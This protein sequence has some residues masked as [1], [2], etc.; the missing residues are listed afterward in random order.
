MVDE[1]LKKA[2]LE[3]KKILEDVDNRMHRIEK[4]FIWNTIFGFLKFLVIWAPIIAGVIYFTPILK[5]Y[6]KIFDP[7]IKNFQ[8][9]TANLI[10]QGGDQPAQLDYAMEAFCDPVARDAMVEEFCK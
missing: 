9:T 2:I 4:K 6:V 1:E 3:N 5:D 10:H 8:S 7:L